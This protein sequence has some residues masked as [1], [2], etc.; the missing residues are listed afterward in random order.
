MFFSELMI[1]LLFLFA[2]KFENSERKRELKRLHIAAVSSDQLMTSFHFKTDK[3]Q[4][5]LRRTP[6]LARNILMQ[7]C[8]SIIFFNMRNQWIMLFHFNTPSDAV[9][10]RKC[11]TKEVEPNK[12]TMFTWMF[13]CGGK[14]Y[15]FI[16]IF[17]KSFGI[18]AR[19]V[20]SVRCGMYFPHFWFSF[21]NLK[22]L[23][24]IRFPIYFST[25]QFVCA[26]FKFIGNGLCVA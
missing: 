26:S 21:R 6:V 23:R 5:L 18:F 2:L 19:L 14:Q 25:S 10:W 7:F 1:C 16:T 24:S 4:H 3:Q 11:S 8:I 12:P 9:E 20:R 22:C 13:Q 15:Q 17:S